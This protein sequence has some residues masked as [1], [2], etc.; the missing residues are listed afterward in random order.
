MSKIINSDTCPRPTTQ[1][2]LGHRLE[3]GQKLWEKYDEF[4]LRECVEQA[5]RH[6]PGKGC[7]YM[8]FDAVAGAPLAGGETAIK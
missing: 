3:D 2:I 7:G 8:F 4:R 1:G 6:C 5:G